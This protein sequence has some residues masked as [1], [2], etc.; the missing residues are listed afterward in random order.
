MT[1]PDTTIDNWRKLTEQAERVMSVAEF[2]LF[3][4]QSRTDWD[5]RP[6]ITREAEKFKLSA[7]HVIEIEQVMMTQF[8][9]V[10]H[11]YFPATALPQNEG[12]IT[13][14]VLMQH[15]RAPT[16]LLDWTLSPYVAT[17][18]AC[19]DNWEDDGAVWWFFD[20]PHERRMRD[21]Y[22]DTKWGP[23]LTDPRAPERIHIIRERAATERMLAQRAAFT[24]C[25]Q[26]MADH[27][28][29]IEG[30][31]EIPAQKGV[32]LGGLGRWIIPAKI[33]RGILENLRAANITAA[34]LFP[35]ADGLGLALKE[36]LMMRMDHVRAFS[37][38]ITMHEDF[39]TMHE[40]EKP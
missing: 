7:E 30:A 13:W 18:F 24:I 33:K 12:S 5:L 23:M 10:A 38:F 31:G 3:R 21:R 14:L 35:G 22:G 20:G 40:P 39:V 6:S 36:M 2:A 28:S 1:W 37:D 26:V 17:Y 27:A 15:Y 4:G 32:Q 25:T 34:S 19:I 16:R 8:Q 29:A 9:Q 11:L